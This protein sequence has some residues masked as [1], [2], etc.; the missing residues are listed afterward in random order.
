MTTAHAATVAGSTGP[1]PRR[2]LVSRH[3]GAHRWLEQQGL[4]ATTILHLDP[5]QVSRGDEVYGTLPLHLA[6]A[7]C[8][9]GARFFCL[10]LDLP[11]SLRGREIDP[12][13]M[14]ALG[15]RIEEFIV[16]RANGQAGVVD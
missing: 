4:Q 5:A 11:A 9:R 1:S 6:A 15:A 8:A 10:A 16:L 7:V 12:E 3:P 13:T 2:W 14:T